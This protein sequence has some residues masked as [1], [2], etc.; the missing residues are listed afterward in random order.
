MNTSDRKTVLTAL[1]TLTG[2]LAAS[3]AIEIVTGGAMGNYNQGATQLKSITGDLIVT[4][5]N[6]P[7]QIGKGRVYAVRSSNGGSTWSA[8]Y[9]VSPVPPDSSHDW[10]GG[11]NAIAQ[12]AGGTIYQPLTYSLASGPS[13]AVYMTTSTDDGLTFSVPDAVS[14]PAGYDGLA[15]YGRMF[16]P[17]SG[18]TWYMPCFGIKTSNGKY[19]SLLL[20]STTPA[21][22]ASWTV[23][24]TIAANASHNYNE[25]TIAMKDASNWVAYIRDE[26]G[27]PDIYQAATSDAGATWGAPSLITPLGLGGVSPDIVISGAGDWI[28][29]QGKR[30]TYPSG[31]WS[32]VSANQGTTWK[33]PI[34]AIS[35]IEAVDGASG[36]GTGYPSV[37]E[38]SSNVFGT[39]FY[40]EPGLFNS[41]TANIWWQK[42]QRASLPV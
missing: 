28:L 12:A 17:D 20:T 14:V 19:E 32:I 27:G 25:T 41:S 16:T 8:P 36:T 13:I 9:P 5:R 35:C 23:K 18:T 4:Y 33:T 6:G 31:I 2:I 1:S 15:S 10:R 22:G 30:G 38:L 40:I 11:E 29:T 24:S 39:P 42:F 26:S 3:P 34:Y 37:V 21:T 7:S